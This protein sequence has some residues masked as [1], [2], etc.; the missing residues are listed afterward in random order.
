ML[1]KSLLVKRRVLMQLACDN[2][3]AVVMGTTRHISVTFTSNP[4][5]LSSLMGAF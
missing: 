4:E 1:K 2:S 5:L 3:V